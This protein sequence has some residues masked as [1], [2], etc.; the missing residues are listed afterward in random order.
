MSQYL[1]EHLIRSIG[2]HWALW[3]FS[4]FSLVTQMDFSNEISGKIG[5]FGKVSVSR[6]TAE[7]RLLK[8]LRDGTIPRKHRAPAIMAF[9]SPI[10]SPRTCQFS[11]RAR[12][13]AI[14]YNKSF[15]VLSFERVWLSFHAFILLP[16][17]DVVGIDRCLHYSSYYYKPSLQHVLLSRLAN[18]LCECNENLP[19]CQVAVSIRFYSR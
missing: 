5:S 16:F 14:T 10:D 13:V 15:V 6:A 2:I 18:D 7:I 8:F 1:E 19:L 4:N 12:R 11:L 17:C 9:R 3:R